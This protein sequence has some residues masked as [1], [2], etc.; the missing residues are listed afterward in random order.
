MGG[1][2]GRIFGCIVEK[3]KLLLSQH[4]ICLEEPVDI[5]SS[6]L[7][8]LRGERS[9]FSYH[10]G[11][12]LIQ[13]FPCVGHKIIA[14]ALESRQIQIFLQKRNPLLRIHAQLHQPLP[15][16]I[17]SLQGFFQVFCRL[18]RLWPAHLEQ[19]A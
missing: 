16:D 4:F 6:V 5:K 12:K 8:L 2:G 18:L 9:K 14:A 13:P 7:Q 1:P 10:G 19:M 11:G 15:C 3:L 17:R